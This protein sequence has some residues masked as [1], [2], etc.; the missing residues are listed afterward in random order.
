[1]IQFY[2]TTQKNIKEIFT[3]IKTISQG[4]FLPFRNN[5]VEIFL[6]TIIASHL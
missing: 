4:L 2:Q 1:M 6:K 3:T 5:I